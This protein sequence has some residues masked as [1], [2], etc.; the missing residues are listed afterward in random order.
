DDDPSDDDT[1][2]DDA[3]DDEEP[4]EDEDE[5][6]DEKEEEHVAPA[7]SSVIPMVDPVP[8]V[9]D[10][11]AFETDESAPIPR[12]PHIRI[13]FAQTRLRRARKTVRPQSPM[14]PSME[15]CIARH[16]AAPSP[17][18]PV[19]SSPLPLPSPLTT[20]PTDTGAPLGYRAAGIRMRAADASP[21]LSLPSTSPRT[22]VLEAEM[23]PQKRAC[24]TNPAPRYKIGESSAAVPQDSQGL[25]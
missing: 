5:D 13:P 16:A 15:A 10:T 3:D 21:P 7:D 18:L 25:L 9:G 4:F 2:D 23:P 24:L 20:S 11:E 14:S 6:E 1:D 12:A 8:S 22:D 17:P 19:A